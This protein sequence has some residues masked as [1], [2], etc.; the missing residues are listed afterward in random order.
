MRCIIASH[1]SAYTRQRFSRRILPY[2]YAV[3]VDGGMDFIIKSMQFSIERYIQIPQ[4]EGQLPTQAVVFANISNMFN[5]ISQESVMNIIAM[6]F[7]ELVSLAHLLYGGPVTVHNCWE[8]GSCRAIEILEGVNQRYP[9][10][11]TFAAMCWIKS[12][13]IS[14]L[15]FVNK[16]MIVCSVETIATTATV[17]SLISLG[18]SMMSRQVCYWWI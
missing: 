9:L 14:M 16:P 8:D 4:Q 13:V 7:P 2:N 17:Q 1:V 6:D 5:S 3:G 12:S 10:S 18:G 11:A 15:S